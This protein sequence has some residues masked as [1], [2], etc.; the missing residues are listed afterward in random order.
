M[1]RKTYKKM[2]TSKLTMAKYITQAIYG[3]AH[4]YCWTWKFGRSLFRKSDF[5]YFI[6]NL[7]TQYPTNNGIW[8]KPF[9]HKV[10]LVNDDY[11]KSR[12]VKIGNITIEY[13]F[14]KTIKQPIVH[15]FGYDAM[16]E[17]IKGLVH[18]TRQSHHN[19]SVFSLA[20][21][22]KEK[23]DGVKYRKSNT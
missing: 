5:D 1:E 2:S 23:S 9:F 18:I 6:R 10:V 19:A 12:S 7:Q 13:S 17:V 22:R 21:H 3:L 16:T 8:T 20:K 14:D 4:A 11:E 15:L